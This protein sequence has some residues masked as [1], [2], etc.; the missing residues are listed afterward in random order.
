MAEIWLADDETAETRVALKV[1]KAELAVKQAHRDHF[2]REWAI[3]S[4][5]MHAHIGRVFE[6]HDEPDGPFYAMQYIAGPDIGVLANEDPD[7]ALPP[8]G[9]LA[10]A[11]RYA[12][13]KALVH[14]D[15]KAGNVL[16]D[17][18]GVPHLIDFGVA[19]AAND[20]SVSG[21]G[22]D[23]AASPEQAAGESPQSSDDIFALGILLYEILTGGPPDPEAVDM[24]MRRPNGQ[25]IDHS[26][27]Q[28]VRDMLAAD[29]NARPSAESVAERLKLAGFPPGKARINI[30]S[31]GNRDSV[32]VAE[33]AIESIRPAR[34]V[35]RNSQTPLAPA[36]ESKGLRPQV[37]F[38]SL[39]VLLLLAVGVIFVLPNSVE[40]EDHRQPLAIEASEIDVE[41]PGV[42]Q[43]V[44]DQVVSVEE[45]M[46]I[47]MATDEALGD[48]LS[49]LERLKYR[50]IERWGGQPYLDVLDVYAEGDK[51]YL[52]KNFATAGDRYREATRLFDPFYDQIEPEFEKSLQAAE[53]A[54]EQLDFIEAIRWYDLAVTITPGH[55]A[56]EKGLKRAISL[57]AVLRLMDQ[58]SLYEDEL[59]LEAA[60]LA[61]EKALGLDP[62]WTP[63]TTA[64]A[65]VR[66]TIEQMSFDARMSEGLEALA[67]N[68][69]DT[70]KAAFN[71][72]KAMHP[73]SR[74][75]V[76]G[77]LQVDQEIRLY[78]IRTME[79][80]VQTQ[81]ANEEWEMAVTTYEAL[82]DVDGDLQFAKEGLARVKA[83]AAMYQQLKGYIADPDAL[84]DP[85]NL[86][87]ATTLLLSASRIEP[88]GPR[89]QDQ[90]KELSILLKRAATPLTV[91]FVS[92]NLTEVSVYKV[93]KLGRFTAK[94]L[95]LRPGKYVAIGIRS[96]YRD[97]RLEFRVSPDIE[98][99]PIV[100]Q[101]EEAI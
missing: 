8:F 95:A 50:G 52:S 69:F 42:G 1:L 51:A 16:L 87:R 41:T 72:A 73:K 89:L 58:G 15:V 93:G 64:L 59:E 71:A 31:T 55:P 46:R 97:V 37:V 78:K 36:I 24:P 9:L 47:K 48:F 90:K 44:D 100:V 10:D 75:P 5:L 84:S 33:P 23:I 6:Y 26:V 81:E 7:V 34:P 86:R 57:E 70:A 28:L 11:L 60:R 94:D 3:A 53:D 14:R 39:G 40:D 85:V 65:R 38:A 68:D 2:H 92:D 29:K 66:Q 88:Q 76:D 17:E 77:L 82:L 83:R 12:H 32:V 43:V 13:G 79:A 56:A 61:Y 49:Q 21:G 63:A 22:S 30:A 25:D 99:I 4:R 18:L 54:F 74:D 19:A 91:R 101:C 35:G 67:T 27:Q 45:V 62:E 98:S 96:G 80:K 20:A